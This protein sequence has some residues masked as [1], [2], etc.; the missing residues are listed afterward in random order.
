MVI[1]TVF[2]N[3]EDSPINPDERIQSRFLE[4]CDT[5]PIFKDKSVLIQP[6]SPGAFKG[7]VCAQRQ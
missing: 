3:P 5:W 2:G 4:E 7:E 1:N 6:R